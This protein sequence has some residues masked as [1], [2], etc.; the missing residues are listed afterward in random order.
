MT[1]PG[2]D[3]LLVAPTTIFIV[4]ET[5]IWS[6][7]FLKLKFGASVGHSFLF[8]NIP[9]LYVTRFKGNKQT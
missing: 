6:L 8:T 1:V 4:S 3:S 9:L 7:F 5:E 2:Y